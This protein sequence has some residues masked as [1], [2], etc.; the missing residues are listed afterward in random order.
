MR[1]S[2]SRAETFAQCPR[3]YKYQYIDG[4]KTIPDQ[5]ANN[6][7]YLGSALHVGLET[8][9]V[10][11]A[12]DNYLSNYY[13]ITDEHINEVI[14]LEY[15]VPKVLEKLP[16]GQCEIQVSA[17]GF[18]GYIDRLCPTY[19]D[20][21]GVQH[22]NLYDYKYT[23]NGERYKTSKQLHIYK[24][25]YELT[26]PDNVIDHLYYVIIGKTSIR[27]R[28]KA[29]PP[30]TIMEFRTRLLEELKKTEITIMEVNYDE[31]SVAYFQE[32]CKYIEECKEFPKNES[33]LCDWCP[34][35]SY[36]QNGE[37]W[38]LL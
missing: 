28:T 29:K 23:S 36:C 5:S 21:K 24:Y 37:D 38:M 16:P 12:V 19:V 30:E 26:H 32:C 7:L 34:Y 31:S 14:K 15:V 4:L 18:I 13:C 25:Y 10:Q 33:R 2:Y 22:W 20:D 8:G 9:D 3:R 35:Q 17:P 1:F 11:A 27:Q 6:A